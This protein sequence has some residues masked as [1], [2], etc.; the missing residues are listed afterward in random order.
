MS[1]PDVRKKNVS[2]VLVY[3]SSNKFVIKRQQ[4]GGDSFGRFLIV[5]FQLITNKT[6]TNVN[7]TLTN[8][9]IKKS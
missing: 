3:G 1:L 7:K 5:L 9:K 6:L 4:F 8:F 2:P